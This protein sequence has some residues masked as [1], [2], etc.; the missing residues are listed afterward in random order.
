MSCLGVGGKWRR[1][2][3]NKL[4]PGYHARTLVYFQVPVHNNILFKMQENGVETNCE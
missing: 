1:F 4:F 3:K 2:H